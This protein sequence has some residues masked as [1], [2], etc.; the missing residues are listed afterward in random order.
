LGFV[1]GGG[2]ICLLEFRP[3]IVQD[4]MTNEVVEQKDASA[5]TDDQPPVAS[6]GDAR[7]VT[8]ASST[9]KRPR[10][11]DSPPAA[12][13]TETPSGTSAEENE[14]L[15]TLSTSAP[16]ETNSGDDSSAGANRSQ[17][18]STRAPDRPAH[19]ERGSES[20]APPRRQ[21]SRAVIRDPD[22]QRDFEVSIR[23]ILVGADVI[24][25]AVI[26]EPVLREHER[27][28]RYVVYFD[29]SVTNRSK[30]GVPRISHEDFRLED[31][32]GMIYSPLRTRNPLSG[33]LGPDE[34]AR[35]GVAFAVYNDSAPA[36]LLIRTGAETF[37]S[38]PESVFTPVGK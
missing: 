4:L 3:D 2:I 34:T 35:G 8:S 30:R 25:A 38:L 28:A 17:R 10:E 9:P 31:G 1:I 6:A 11:D 16:D 19:S 24:A 13:S 27:S 37:H 18:P 15:A 22:I 20:Q 36:R 14:A 26:D 23:R 29:L 5:N 21:A 33:R 12:T 7:L 32:K